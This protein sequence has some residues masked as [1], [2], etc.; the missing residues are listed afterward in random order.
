MLLFNLRLKY[1]FLSDDALF[2][3]LKQVTFIMINIGSNT[4]TKMDHL[5]R[6]QE[7]VVT[8]VQSYIGQRVDR[9]KLTD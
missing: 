2:T 9:I 3:S 5:V 8:L 7:K 6:R 1:G 4:K